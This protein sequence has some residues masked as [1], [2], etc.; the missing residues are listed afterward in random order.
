MKVLTSF[1]LVFVL[2]SCNKYRT[3]DH[4]GLIELAFQ[5]SEIN[6]TFGDTLELLVEFKN[7]DSIDLRVPLDPGILHLVEF[8]KR[9]FLNGENYLFRRVGEAGATPI[10]LTPGSDTVLNT[11][12]VPLD[13]VNYKSAYICELL[14]SVVVELGGPS[15]SLINLSSNYITINMVR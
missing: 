6:Y 10:L 1:V 11:K 3:S 12:F 14:I 9:D 2:I 8:R 5:Q 4:K 7:Y 13:N 15:V